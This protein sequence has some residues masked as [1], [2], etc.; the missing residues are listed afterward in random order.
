MESHFTFSASSYSLLCELHSITL[1]DT[2]SLDSMTSDH[3]ESILPHQPWALSLMSRLVFTFSKGTG[4]FGCF[5][6][7]VPLLKCLKRCLICRTCWAS[8]PFKVPKYGHPKIE[9]PQNH[10]TNVDWEQ[11]LAHRN[12]TLKHGQHVG[13]SHPQHMSHLH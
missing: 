9:T 12:R 2:F 11:N 8:A 4:D 1:R 5:A 10:D 13:L 7:W 3:G 6:F